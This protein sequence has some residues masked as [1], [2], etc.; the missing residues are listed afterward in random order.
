MPPRGGKFSPQVVD[1]IIDPLQSTF[2][3]ELFAGQVRNLS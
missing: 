3:G 1:T 2:Y